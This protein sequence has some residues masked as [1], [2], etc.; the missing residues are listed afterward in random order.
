MDWEDERYIRAYTRDTVAFM[1]LT[2]QARG[3]FFLIL[4]KV[5]RAG[6]LALEKVGLRGV[7]VAVGGPW[8]EIETPLRELLDDG[9]VVYNETLS[10]LVVP[11]YLAAQEATQTDAARQRKHRET[12]RARMMAGVTDRD[13]IGS[14]S[15]TDQQTHRDALSL[16][17]HAESRQ[18]TPSDP[19]KPNQPDLV[20]PKVVTERNTPLEAREPAKGKGPRSR[21]TAPKP[22]PKP[23]GDHQRVIDAWHVAYL[24]A[25]G[26]APTW[27]GANLRAAKE[28]RELLGAEEA[29]KVMRRACEDEGFVRRKGS[30]SWLARDPDQFRI[31]P[32]DDYEPY[33]HP[34][35][36]GFDND[37]NWIG[38]EDKRPP[39]TFPEAPKIADT[40]TAEEHAERQAKVH[41]FRFGKAGAA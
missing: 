31:A 19:A 1:T 23:T 38:P 39:P 37:G 29:I 13:A 4:R 35:P 32:E 26:V 25:F 9:C 7:S 6:T 40:M 28:L 5:D 3:L 14:Q 2:W 36:E 15:V 33:L 11:N 41:A 24:E 27:T 17:G 10:T 18:V 8:R 21:K 12:R 30:V 34:P 16:G 20:T 22:D